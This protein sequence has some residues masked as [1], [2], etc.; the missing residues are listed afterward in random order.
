MAAYLFDSS[1]LVKAYLTE[2]GTAWVRSIVDDKDNVVHVANLTQVELV[3]ACT[4]R[5]RRGDITQAEFDAAYDES[6]LDRANLF[7]IVSVTDSVIEE[8]VNLAKSRGLRA[9]DAIQLAA[10]LDVDR[11]VSEST[12]DESM[13]VILVSADSELNAAAEL[14]GLN[15]EDPNNH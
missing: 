3:S 6:Q 14:E 9:Y 8:A 12:K 15:V 5:L 13:H 4:R 2:T 11:F 10:A 1:A 7:E